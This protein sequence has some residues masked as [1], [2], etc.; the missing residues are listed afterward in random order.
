[1]RGRETVPYDRLQRLLS[2]VDPVK[3]AARPL[4]AAG[5]RALAVEA[6]EVVEEEHAAELARVAAAARA[7]ASDA[8]ESRAAA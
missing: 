8:P 2:D 4:D 7:A 6:R 1:M 5:A 3:F